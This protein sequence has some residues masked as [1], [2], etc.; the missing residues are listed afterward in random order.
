M[1]GGFIC[2]GHGEASALPAEEWRLVVR[3]LVIVH[4]DLTSSDGSS[5]TPMFG[6]SRLQ[7]VG[8][9]QPAGSDHTQVMSFPAPGAPAQQTLAPT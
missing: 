5:N 1:T 6:H 7:R 9:T 8:T 4:T 3:A 2:L